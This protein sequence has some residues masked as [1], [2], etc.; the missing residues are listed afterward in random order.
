MAALGQ[1]S[2]G[3]AH[4]INT[5]LGA[6]N[7][8]A[9]QIRRFITQT[10]HTL[11]KLFH[12]LSPEDTEEFLKIINT[13]LSHNLNIYS[14][15]QQRYYR[16]VLTDLLLADFKNA[17]TIADILVDIGYY[18]HISDIL[19]ILKK[20]TGEQLLE[21]IYQIS[22]L[23]RSSQTISIA[24]EKAA[25]VVFAL[26]SYATS[27]YAD[28]KIETD[29]IQ[30]IETVLM[31]YQNWLK[32]DIVLIKEYPQM[33]P[34]ILC[35]PNDIKQVWTNLILNALQAMNYR[36]TLMIQVTLQLSMLVIMFQ[37]SGK[38]IAESDLPYIFQ[39]FFTT[40]SAGEGCGLGLYIVKQIIE[41]HEGKIEVSSVA[42]CTQFW[43]YLP[44]LTEN[45]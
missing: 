41:K 2:A 38:G 17:D 36:G 11:P 1:L 45:N 31:L 8:S 28:S 18:H 23:N 42:G 4:E 43:I 21:L 24:T 14:T 5:P 3:V 30:S 16:R 33:M 12:A 27:I 7:A 22:E 44:L 6:I 32:N 19:P 40:K 29:I 39:A 26:K 15:K 25:K 13:V 10:I 20:E 35:Y 34:T 9:N 37:D